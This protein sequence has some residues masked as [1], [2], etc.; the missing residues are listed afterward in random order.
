MHFTPSVPACGTTQALTQSCARTSATP[1]GSEAEGTWAFRNRQVREL[2]W[3]CAPAL[4]LGLAL[5]VLMTWQMPYGYMQFDSADFLLTAHRFLSKHELIIHSKRT[6]LVP[7]LYT[8]PFILKIPALIVIPVAQH[9]LGLGVVLMSGLLARLWFRPWRWVVV[10]LTLLMAANPNF[11]WFEHTLMSE[12]VYLYCVFA[13]A[14]AATLFTIHPTGRRF[15]ILS[16]ALFF[17]AS[18]R[19][20]GRLLLG[21]GFLLVVLVEWGNWKTLWLRLGCLIALAG[22]T[23]P[24]TRTGQAGQL[25]YATVLP[26]A[27]DES[28]VD[29]EF[30]RLVRPLR[31]QVR[32]KRHPT[33]EL[34]GLEQKLTDLAATHLEAKGVVNG[35]TNALC[36]KMAFEACLNQPL[37]IPLVVE[38]KFLRSNDSPTSIGYDEPRLQQKLNVGF[39]R[40]NM[41]NVLSKGLLGQELKG[42][43]AVWEFVREHYHPFSW[44][45]FLDTNWR[46]FTIGLRDD[47][48][49]P[50]SA[51]TPHWATFF[52]LG[53]AGFAMALV[54]PGPL[55]R[56]HLAWVPS[57]CGLWFAVELAGVVNPR[58]RFVFEPFCLIYAILGLTIVCAMVAGAFRPRPRA[59]AS[60]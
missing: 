1:R 42:E 18:A 29:P 27:P 28:K 55:R 47:E 15:A 25:L 54:A 8:L 35:D 16:L 26:L 9:L 52:V 13:L 45:R 3:Y 21:F 50:G 6:Y 33:A 36:Q 57:L 10:P 43:E 7:I 12:S 23:L 2:L 44:Y 46:R 37:E 5:R 32:T 48:G 39:N 30:G 34:Q 24:L 17:A 59:G 40:K 22:V 38:R 41:L 20:E 49:I 51:P 56:F 53:F 31:D 58:Y 4:L 14:L 19:P 60:T 11:L